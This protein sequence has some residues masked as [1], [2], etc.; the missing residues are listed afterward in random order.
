M[1]ERFHQT[2][3]FRRLQLSQAV[4]VRCLSSG[5]T[6]G[7]VIRITHGN[8]YGYDTGFKRVPKGRVL[9]PEPIAV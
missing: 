9:N 3:C 5:S 2:F 1:R 6:L 4:A 7:R 8:S